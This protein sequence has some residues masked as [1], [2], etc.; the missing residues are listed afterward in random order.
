ME[1]S[2]IDISHIRQAKS[3]EV[4]AVS[5]RR[6]ASACVFEEDALSRGMIEAL[7][8]STR[9]DS[10]EDL[11]RLCQA[12]MARGY[13]S[14]GR[15][16][17]L[18]VKIHPSVQGQLPGKGWAFIWELDRVCEDLDWL[19]G[20]HVSVEGKLYLVQSIESVPAYPQVGDRLT[21]LCSAVSLDER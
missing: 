18:P 2:S 16:A 20:A 3:E 8:M 5:A 11:R 21:L 4:I 7:L 10:D 9:A 13:G 17:D 15:V 19:V 14:E 12:L 1:T 6:R